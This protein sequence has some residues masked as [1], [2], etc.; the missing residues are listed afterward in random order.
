MVIVVHDVMQKVYRYE[1]QILRWGAF[2]RH[3]VQVE[4]L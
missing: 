4:K 1:K 2:A 3:V